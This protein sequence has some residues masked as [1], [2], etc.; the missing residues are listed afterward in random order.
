MKNCRLWSRLL[1]AAAI[2]ALLTV[3]S[4]LLARLLA[5]LVVTVAQ[6]K[7][8]TSIINQIHRSII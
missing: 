5:A 3:L 4:D 6:G 7:T 1:V 8:E 2:V